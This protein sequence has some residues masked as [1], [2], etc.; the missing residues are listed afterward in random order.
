MSHTIY[1]K[2]KLLSR[3]RRIRGQ[4][5]AIERVL[6]AEAG[7]AQV[8]HLIAASR[9]AIWSLTPPFSWSR[10]STAISGKYQKMFNRDSDYS[11]VFPG[12]GHARSERK[13]WTVIALCGVM[14]AVEII[15]G[16]VFGSV[17]LMADG[18]HMSTH[19]MG[20]C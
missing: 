8:M 2:Q 12:A 19:A 3:A 9:G 20:R 6:E 11:R 16:S 13:A 15:G 17:A 5:E 7:C 18:L 1:Q 10:S 14:M 4:L